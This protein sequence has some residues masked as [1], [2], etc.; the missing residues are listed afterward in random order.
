MGGKE[1]VVLD[2]VVLIGK[3]KIVIIELN[4]EGEGFKCCI[5]YF[6]FLRILLL[7]K[8]EVVYLFL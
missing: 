3:R 4:K 8:D 6:C 2:N 1:S 7:F 5:R